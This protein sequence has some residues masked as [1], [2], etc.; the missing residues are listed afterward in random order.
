MAS[1]LYGDAVQSYN[2]GDV[3]EAKRKLQ[4]TLQVDKT[5]RPASDL[6]NRISL[7][8]QQAKT[9]GGAGPAPV[10]VRVL[11]QTSFPLEFKDTSLQTALEYIRQQADEKSGGK[12]QMNFVLQVPPEIANKKITLRLN[13][14]P[15]TEMLHYIGDLAGVK[16]QVQKYAIVVLPANLPDVADP[17]AATPHP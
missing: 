16:F 3:A 7:A 15:V 8:E 12:A 10:S 6:L 11:E 13:H 2:S 4:L 17:A 14:V 1:Q 9:G 5:F